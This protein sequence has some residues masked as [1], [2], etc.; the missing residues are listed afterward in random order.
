M[1]PPIHRAVAAHWS[2]RPR[3][4]WLGITAPPANATPFAEKPLILS[5]L[6]NDRRFLFGTASSVECYVSLRR[7]FYGTNDIFNRE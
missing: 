4:G 6:S 2:T 7:T 5:T 3:N 1:Q